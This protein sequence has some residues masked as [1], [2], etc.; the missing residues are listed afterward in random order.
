MRTEPP[1]RQERQESARITYDLLQDAQV[2]G[3]TQ[4]ANGNTQYS[5]ASRF[6]HHVS[7][8]VVRRLSS[9]DAPQVVYYLSRVGVALF[10]V[11]GVDFFAINIHIELPIAAPGESDALQVVPV[12]LN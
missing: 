11:L 3:F 12:F 2:L 5:H 4:N 10:F 6:T 8:P 7:P 9:Y 1:R